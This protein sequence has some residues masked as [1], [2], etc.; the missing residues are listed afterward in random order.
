MAF[1]DLF[2][3]PHLPVESEEKEGCR[4]DTQQPSPRCLLPAKSSA[5]PSFSSWM[6]ILKPFIS[7]FRHVYRVSLFCKPRSYCMHH[8]IAFLVLVVHCEVFMC[9]HIFSVVLSIKYVVGYQTMN[10]FPVDRQVS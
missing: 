2:P 9:M 4:V 7:L 5:A 6:R 10:W 1:E 8:S 3:H